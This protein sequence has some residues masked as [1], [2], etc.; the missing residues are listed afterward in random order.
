MTMT[1]GI[2]I[3]AAAPGADATQAAAVIDFQ[4]ALLLLIIVCVGFLAKALADLN[5]RVRELSDARTRSAAPPPRA[6]EQPAAEGTIAPQLL[7]VITAAVVTALDQPARIVAVDE[8]KQAQA[9]T[10]SLEG[11]RQIFSSHRVR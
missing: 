11:R 3:A 8:L 6:L 1:P 2:L 7:A 10:W 4:T 9:G 5:R